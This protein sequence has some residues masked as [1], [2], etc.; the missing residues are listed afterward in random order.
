MNPL[1][2]MVDRH[3]PLRHP[4]RLGDRRSQPHRQ[5]PARPGHSRTGRNRADR[6]P[7]GVDR[8]KQVI[9]TGGFNVCPSEVEDVL[10]ELPEIDDLA[11][12]GVRSAG[13]AGE[14]VVV[15]VVP[16]AGATVDPERVRAY[17]HERLTG[18]KVPR[19]VVMLEEL[20]RSQIGKIFRRRVATGSK[21]WRPSM[22]S[23]LGYLPCHGWVSPYVG[24]CGE[25]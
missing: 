21:R 7:A 24:M 23:E 6:R 20:P 17:A 12:V 16:A 19:R 10:R 2:E 18:Y 11:V 5:H 9:I 14:E 15:A 3:R 4:D 1:R 13:D 8:I 22:P 25:G